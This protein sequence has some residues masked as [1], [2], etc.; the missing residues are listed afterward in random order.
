MTTLREAA[1]QALEALEELNGWQSLAPPV[2]SQV[3]RHA[4]INLR[5]A[6]EQPEPCQYPDCVDNGPEGKCT[7]W[8]LAE[9][10]KSEDYKPHRPAEPDRAQKMRDA[11]YTRRPTLREMAEPVQEPVAWTATRLW[12][13]KELWTCPA[14]IERDL[15]EGYARP[16]QREWR[17]LSEEEIAQV[18]GFGDYTAR[19][20]EVTL[21]VIARAVEAALRS[22]NYG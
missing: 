12:N 9:C 3:G 10:S 21:T 6:L 5:A 19:S 1:Q 14:D 2:A 18:L 20:T 7:R 11:G 13:R 22:K 4:A 8:L 17:S 15:L 16:P